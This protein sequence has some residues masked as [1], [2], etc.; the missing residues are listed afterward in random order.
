MFQG[1]KDYTRRVNPDLH[2]ACVRDDPDPRGAFA[3]CSTRRR[4][5]ILRTNRRGRSEGCVSLFRILIFTSALY[6]SPES[7]ELPVQTAALSASALRRTRPGWTLWAGP[8][9]A[10]LRN[11]FG[12]RGTVRMHPVLRAI[13]EPAAGDRGRAG[14][15]RRGMRGGFGMG[16]PSMS[17]PRRPVSTRSTAHRLEQERPL[18]DEQT[19]EGR[20]P[21][22]TDADPKVVMDK[23]RIFR[24]RDRSLTCRT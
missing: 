9:P 18:A 22:R 24:G 15:R 14:D 23:R 3:G 10:A 7:P 19:D 11:R 17:W 16:R 12:I 6:L 5:F 21:T 8:Q 13:A 1:G 2:A 20:V 4:D